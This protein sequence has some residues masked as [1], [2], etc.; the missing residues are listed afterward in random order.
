MTK[1]TFTEKISLWLDNELDPAE[2]S[3]LQSHLAGCPVCRQTYEAMRQVDH[4]L[5]TAAKQM[6]PPRPGFNQRFETR[7]ARHRPGRP[8]QIWLTMGALSL[9]ALLVFFGWAIV[10]GMALEADS[11]SI[12]E[13]NFYYQGVVA[14]IE[15]ADTLRFF[16]NLATLF[17]KTSFILMQQPLFW[18]GVLI[19]MTTIWLW[20]RLLQTLPRRATANVQLIF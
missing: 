5:Q 18:G 13:A 16:L 14:F 9:A 17:L 2:V 8:W 10:E 12:F 4:L 7:L 15:S 20:V 3:E 11:T 1:D 6:A 19:A